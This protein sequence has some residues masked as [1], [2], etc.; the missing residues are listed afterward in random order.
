MR[1]IAD[2]AVPVFAQVGNHDSIEDARTALRLY[3]VYQRLEE[4]GQ[5]GA[6]LQVPR[7]AQRGVDSGPDPLMSTRFMH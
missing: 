4:S 1:D 3:E 5:F 6:K 7:S 2:V